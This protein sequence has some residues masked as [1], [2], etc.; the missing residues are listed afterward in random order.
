VKP[1]DLGSP[2][3]C[4]APCRGAGRAFLR[5]FRPLDLGAVPRTPG[6]T[7]G[8]APAALQAAGDRLLSCAIHPSSALGYNSKANAVFWDFRGFFRA[9]WRTFLVG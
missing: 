3:P 5:P 9:S 4:L 6:F 7:R 1:R 2:R 8:W